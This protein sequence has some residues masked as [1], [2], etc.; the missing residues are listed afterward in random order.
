MDSKRDKRNILLL[1]LY[2][3]LLLTEENA[4]KRQNT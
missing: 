4:D 2:D 1:R 3:I